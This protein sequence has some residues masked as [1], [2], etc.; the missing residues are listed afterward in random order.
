MEL[1]NLVNSFINF[2]PQTTFIKRLPFL[3]A[4]QAGTLTVPLLWIYLTLLT[5]LFVLQHLSL[6]WVQFWSSCCLS[7]H[8]LYLKF[9]RGCPFSSNSLWL[10]SCW[11]GRSSWPFDRYSMGG[12]HTRSSYCC[13][14]ILSADPGWNYIS[15]KYI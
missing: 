14:W 13:Y 2:L 6:H 9:T 15:W 4:S 3:L 5:I 7:F 1:K 12:Y 8:W 10:F 11:L